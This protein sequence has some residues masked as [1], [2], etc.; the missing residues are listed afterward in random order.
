M[1][2]PLWLVAFLAVVF[3]WAPANRLLGWLLDWCS[4]VLVEAAFVAFRSLGL[5]IGVEKPRTAAGAIVNLVAQVGLTIGI[6]VAISTV[7]HLRH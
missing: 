2:V 4:R 1:W 7:F 6:G 3:F 5:L